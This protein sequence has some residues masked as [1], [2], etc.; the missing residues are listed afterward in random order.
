V[1]DV[2]DQQ[3]RKFWIDAAKKLCAAGEMCEAHT[4]GLTSLAYQYQWIVRKEKAGIRI[5]AMERGN[6]NRM[7]FE[8]GLID[9][10]R[11]W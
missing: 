3:G 2:L 10:M 4:F 7:C 9:R 5:S 8:Y 6:F 11:R 1:P